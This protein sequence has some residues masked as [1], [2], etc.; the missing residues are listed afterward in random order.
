MFEPGP[1]WCRITTIDAHTAG[2]RLRV[3]T[4]GAGETMLA[5]RRHAREHRDD[6]RPALMWEP[7]GH[8]EMYSCLLTRPVTPDGCV[9]VH[10]LHDEG[11]STILGRGIIGLVYLDTEH[12]LLPVDSATPWPASTLRRVV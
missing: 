6:L 1:G 8:T 3:I 12:G 5:Q 9:G 4:G 10:F 2:E 11:S 7:R